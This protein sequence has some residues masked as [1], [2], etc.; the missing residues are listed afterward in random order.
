MDP[1]LLTSEKYPLYAESFSAPASLCMI[2]CIFY[3]DETHIRRT[4]PFA[5]QSQESFDRR[6]G[7]WKRHVA[8]LGAL[9][10]ETYNAVT[11]THVVATAF[12][13]DC[14]QRALKDDVRV[15]TPSWIDW[16][17]FRRKMSH[18]INLL[19]VP[20][21]CSIVQPAPGSSSSSGGASNAPPPPNPSK[22]RVSTSHFRPRTSVLVNTALAMFS[23]VQ[24]TKMLYRDT[25][26]ILL[27]RPVGDKYTTATKFNKP[28]LNLAWLRDML[29]NRE[30]DEQAWTR[31]EYRV[32]EN[33]ATKA[34][35]L[36]EKCAFSQRILKPWLKPIKI[37]VDFEQRAKLRRIEET[38]TTSFTVSGE[39]S[40]KKSRML[41]YKPQPRVI[42]SGI[43]KD[44]EKELIR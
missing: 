25:D 17:A 43:N 42:F 7:D 16:I 11:C 19:H 5:K 40:P 28:A 13:T 15:V 26:L 20:L 30:M 33:G 38:P 23:K 36:D 27:P 32:K 8:L 24:V 39:P 9:V 12:N 21:P 1:S 29:L 10:E 4:L 22:I 3:F 35:C 41:C 37:E 18:P 6:V 44:D 14:V 2:G 31:S 34:L